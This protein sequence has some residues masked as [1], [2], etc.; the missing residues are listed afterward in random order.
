MLK[1]KWLKNL[2][3][4][5]ETNEIRFSFF[6]F[7]ISLIEKLFY[8]DIIDIDINEKTGSLLYVGYINDHWEFD[9]LFLRNIYYWL[10][11]RKL[12]KF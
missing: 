2:K 8:F 10:I 4:K 1:I 7:K 11:F 6:E 12:R 5:I 9:I 3:K